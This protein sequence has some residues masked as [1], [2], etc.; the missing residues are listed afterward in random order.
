MSVT[1][2]HLLFL[3]GAD[4]LMRSC[5]LPE[6]WPLRLFICDPSGSSKE[7]A[8]GPLHSCSG[9]GASGGWVEQDIAGPLCFQG[10]RLAVGK[11]L[12]R[13]CAGD[14][15]MVVDVGAVSGNQGW[16]TMNALRVST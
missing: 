8:A 9:G 2:R 7:A 11:L 4:L 15:V 3:A 5:Y 10:D 12:P 16:Q 13:T 6:T 1:A 14:F